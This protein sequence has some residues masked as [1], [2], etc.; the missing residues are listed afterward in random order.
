MVAKKTTWSPVRGSIPSFWD[1]PDIDPRAL[2]AWVFPLAL[3][4]ADAACM[5]IVRLMPAAGRERNSVFA[6]AALAYFSGVH[7]AAEPPVWLRNLVSK[8]L[9]VGV[10]FTA[11]CAAPTLPV[12]AVG[13]GYSTSAMASAGTPWW[14]PRRQPAPTMQSQTVTISDATPSVT[15]Y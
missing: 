12:I 15:I 6:A 3:C 1:W 8:D 11:G 4:S 5:L 10:I 7:A 14:R 9:L 13:S 2:M